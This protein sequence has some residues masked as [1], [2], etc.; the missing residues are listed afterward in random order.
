MSGS[1]VGTNC[2]T[3]G[4]PGSVQR[5]ST[6]GWVSA[7]QPVRSRIT[8]VPMWMRNAITS[9]TNCKRPAWCGQSSGTMASTPSWKGATAVVI[10]GAP[11][12][13]SRSWCCAQGRRRRSIYILWSPRAGARAL[14]SFRSSR[15][16]AARARH[17]SHGE[18][19][20]IPYRATAQAGR[21][22]FCPYVLAPA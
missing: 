1:G 16:V 2:T 4:P 15:R 17:L 6:S 19:W 10:A 9:Q 3:A 22:A 20:R 7:T 8:S 13:A 21:R 5:H 14:R 12:V 18:S 11:M